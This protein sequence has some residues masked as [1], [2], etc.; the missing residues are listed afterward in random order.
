MQKKNFIKSGI[1]V[2][3]LVVASM[4]GFSAAFGYGGSGGGVYTPSV[5]T[6][7]VYADWQTCANGL[8]Y[9]NITSQ[10]PLNCTLSASQQAARSQN[11]GNT[12]VITTPVAVQKVLG[13]QAYANGTLLRGTDKKIYVVTNGALYH[14][15]TLK[16]LA[17]YPG[18]EILD[19]NDSVIAS[20]SKT[21]VLGV[22][23]FANGALIRGTDKKIYVIVNG[24]KQHILDLAELAKYY[25]KEVLNVS[26]SV[27]AQ[28]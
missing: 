1:A 9:R 19:V 27:I 3:C 11:C 8:Q 18:K 17:K 5:C 7:V 16:Q 22:Q 13:V 10:G 2:A 28:Y 23:T 20:F 24:A 12:P 15:A 14:I 21:A 4:F 26:D 25:G 6:S